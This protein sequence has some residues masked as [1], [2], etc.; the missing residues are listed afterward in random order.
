M[1]KF[2]QFISV[3]QLVLVLICWWLA[4]Y[5]PSGTVFT[6][7]QTVNDAAVLFLFV[8]INGIIAVVST[9]QLRK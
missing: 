8:L 9:M 3:Y 1:W 4:L 6:W 5:F 7:Q 2:L